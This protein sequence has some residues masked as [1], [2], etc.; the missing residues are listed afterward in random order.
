MDKIT[1]DQRSHNM[2]RIK[3]KDTSIEVKVRKFL[4][5]RGFRYRKNVRALPGTPDIVLP[6]YKTVIFVN[7]CFWH[8]HKGCKYTT[9]PSTHQDFWQKKFAANVS[10]DKKHYRQLKDLGWHVIVLWECEIEH[11]FFEV[12][13]RVINDLKIH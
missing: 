3:S 10:N 2:A 12:M 7:G 4:F 8:R 11:T 5:A 1:K 13:N 6:K 9:T